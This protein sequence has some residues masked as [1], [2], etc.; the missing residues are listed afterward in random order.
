MIVS[1]PVSSVFATLEA[2][3]Q[4]AVCYLLCSSGMILVVVVSY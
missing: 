1:P 4:A 3:A 2:E